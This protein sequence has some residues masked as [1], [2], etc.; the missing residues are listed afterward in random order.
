ME[1]RKRRIFKLMKKDGKVNMEIFMPQHGKFFTFAG[2]FSTQEELQKEVHTIH[3]ELQHILEEAKNLFEKNV[4]PASELQQDMDAE[5]IWKVLN[6]I[7]DEQQFIVTFNSLHEKKRREVAN[8]VFTQCN[9]F[10]GKASV[11]SLRYNSDSALLE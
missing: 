8:F 9:A 4:I 5:Q 1:D 7:K 2:P 3:V 10:A 11:F 6:N